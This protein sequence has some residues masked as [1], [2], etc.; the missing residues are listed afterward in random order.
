M[1]DKKIFDE[2]YVEASPTTTAPQAKSQLREF[3]KKPIQDSDLKLYGA[4]KPIRITVRAE[5]IR[6]EPD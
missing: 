2:K 4:S 3:L 5:L 1:S 6:D